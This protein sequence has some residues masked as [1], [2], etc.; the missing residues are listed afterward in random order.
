MYIGKGECFNTV[1]WGPNAL[2]I[3]VINTNRNPAAHPVPVNLCNYG[4][5][6]VVFIGLV[7]CV[8]K[9]GNWRIGEISAVG[10]MGASEMGRLAS[11]VTISDGAILKPLNW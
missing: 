2:A 3:K 7:S 11:A 5:A 10:F 1:D 6:R 8:E 4:C 9:T